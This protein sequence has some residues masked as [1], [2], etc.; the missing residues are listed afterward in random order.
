MERR[1]FWSLIIL[2][3]ALGALSV[4][5]SVLWGQ[6]WAGFPWGAGIAIAFGTLGYSWGYKDAKGDK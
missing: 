1:T 5:V 3:L 2:S 6:F 4:C